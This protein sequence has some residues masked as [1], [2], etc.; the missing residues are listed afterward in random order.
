MRTMF[1]LDVNGT[2]RLAKYSFPPVACDQAHDGTIALNH[3][4]KMCVCDGA[5][6][7]FV[8]DDLPCSW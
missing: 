1:A 6:W 7:R 4:T 2:A 8:K 3:L 5:T